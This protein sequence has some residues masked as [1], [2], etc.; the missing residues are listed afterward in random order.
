MKSEQKKLFEDFP[1]LLDILVILRKEKE[2]SYQSITEHFNNMGYKC[3]RRLIE[4]MYKKYIGDIQRSRCGINNSFYGKTHSDKTRKEISKAR[5]DSGI[6]SGNKNPMYGRTGENSPG[7]KGGKSTKCAIFYSSPDW[8][9]KRLEIMI[10][11]NF[12]CLQCEKEAKSK[13]SFLNVHH[14]IPLSVDWEKRLNNDNLITLCVAC[15]KNT[16]G[17]EVELISKFQD[18]VRTHGRP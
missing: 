11:D 12:T 8:S 1:D 15:H 4:R 13:H 17:K 6:S 3:S 7:W 9:T 5:V 18:I 2:M 10:R 16:F 14:I